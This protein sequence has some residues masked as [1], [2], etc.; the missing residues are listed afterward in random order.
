MTEMRIMKY[1][2]K[3][4]RSPM[5]TKWLTY[6]LVAAGLLFLCLSLTLSLVATAE[7]DIIGGAGWPT[8]SLVFFRENGGVY[9]LMA[10]AG[11]ASLIAAL[12]LSFFKQKK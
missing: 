1:I 11:A 5:R 6:A 4:A 9:F 8:F 7:K 10:L 3:E 2:P 12:V